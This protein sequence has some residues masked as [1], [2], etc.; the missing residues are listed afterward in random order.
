MT[1]KIML[2]VYLMNIWDLL[3]KINRINFKICKLEIIY[4][5]IIFKEDIQ[6]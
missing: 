5:I 1:K 4:N 2:R 6:I 3:I